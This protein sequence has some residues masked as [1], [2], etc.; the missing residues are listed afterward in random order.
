MTQS[1]AHVLD[2]RRRGHQLP[3]ARDE[4]VDALALEQHD[5]RPAAVL[6]D[7][8]E[9]GVAERP[10]AV[11]AREALARA[12]DVEVTDPAAE[13]VG[14]HRRLGDVLDRVAARL[15]VGLRGA[16]EPAARP[17]ADRVAGDA[18]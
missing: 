9:P 11:A 2:G 18:G 10:A 16:D 14:D 17:L 12:V 7:R 4:L 3:A 15:A 13:Q 1:Y 6:D 5:P 8:P